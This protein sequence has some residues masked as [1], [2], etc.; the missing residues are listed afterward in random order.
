M[1]LSIQRRVVVQDANSLESFA[2]SERVVAS[3]FRRDDV[4]LQIE[5]CQVRRNLTGKNEFARLLRRKQIGLRR[6]TE[7][8]A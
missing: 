8:L 1:T 5:S 3:L 4:P 7:E 2:A 6:Q